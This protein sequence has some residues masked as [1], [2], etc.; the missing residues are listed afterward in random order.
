MQT[1]ENAP[2][3]EY[4]GRCYTLLDNGSVEADTLAGLRTFPSLDDFKS[5][6]SAPGTSETGSGTKGFLTPS[7]RIVIG[8]VLV[9]AAAASYFLYFDAEHQ[10]LLNVSASPMG[11]IFAHDPEGRLTTA[12][13]NVRLVQGAH[14]VVGLLGL[15]LAGSGLLTLNRK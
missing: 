3:G 15:A 14:L 8:L 12:V 2:S 6:V 13:R 5:Y 11:A 1:T 9:A 7:A 10:R 4:K